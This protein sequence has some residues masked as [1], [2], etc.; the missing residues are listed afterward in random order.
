MNVLRGPFIVRNF[1]KE[2]RENKMAAGVGDHTWETKL[3]HKIS[4]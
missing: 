2:C 1:S 3:Y 4:L